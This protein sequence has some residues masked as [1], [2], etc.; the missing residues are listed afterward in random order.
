MASKDEEE[1]DDEDEGEEEVEEEAEPSVNRKGDMME[2]EIL[3]QSEGRSC[4]LQRINFNFYKTSYK[5]LHLDVL[6]F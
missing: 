5:E 2:S 6:A 3:P 1:W 4:L